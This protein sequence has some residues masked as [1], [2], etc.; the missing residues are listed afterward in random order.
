LT[1]IC[2]YLANTLGRRVIW[3]IYFSVG[4]WILAAWEERV[5]F[6]WE[7]SS[8]EMYSSKSQF[9]SL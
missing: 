2:A 5:W 6:C 8:R 7:G 4:W 1:N 9:G 3:P